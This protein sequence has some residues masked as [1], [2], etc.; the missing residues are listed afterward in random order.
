MV[1]V[2]SGEAALEALASN[3]FDLIVTD[4]RMPEMDGATLLQLVRDRYPKVIRLVLSGQSDLESALRTVPIAH[5]FLSKPCEPVRLRNIL[6]RACHLQDLLDDE[7][8]RSLI[9]GVSALPPAPRT[10]QALTNLI[11][12]P[13]TSVHE[14]ASLVEQDIALSAKVLQ[15]VNS[16][17][18]GLPQSVTSVQDAVKYLGTNLVRNL[19]LMFEVFGKFEAAVPLPGFSLERIQR[20]AILTAQVAKQFFTTKPQM[21]GAFTAGLL[22]DVGCLIEA[23]AF[24][25]LFKQAL[26]LSHERD[27]PLHEAE[28]EVMGTSHAEVGAY[29]LGLWGVPHSIVEAVAYHDAPWRVDHQGLDIL[30]AVHIAERLVA[31]LTNDDF[32]G[33]EKPAPIANAYADALASA[34]QQAVWREIA[35]QTVSAVPAAP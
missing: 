17:Y 28:R 18:F 6:E 34:E 30:D 8:L 35:R 12:H 20:H 24:P 7:H 26:E 16:A 33:T 5:Q 13:D 25:G 3:T 1:F 21:D 32:S 27:C 19:V 31:E 4:M 9:D 29:L 2:T 15:I 14:I 22:H 11:S 10:Y 23:T